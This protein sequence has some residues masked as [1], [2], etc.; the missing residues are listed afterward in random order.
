MGKWYIILCS[1]GHFLSSV[2]V[3]Y[4]KKKKKITPRIVM[5]TKF[6]EFCGLPYKRSTVR[7]KTATDY[8]TYIVL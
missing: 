2:V 3:F 4:Q 1:I 5:L 8:N 6:S 7:C